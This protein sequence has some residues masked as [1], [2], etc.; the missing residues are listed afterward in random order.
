[1]GVTKTGGRNA[2]QAVEIGLALRRIEARALT[3]FEG[4]LSAVVDAEQMIGGGFGNVER[5]HGRELP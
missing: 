4:Q 3:A 1:M 2:G 5:R